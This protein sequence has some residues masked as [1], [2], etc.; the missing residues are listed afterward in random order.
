MSFKALVA[1]L[2][3]VPHALAQTSSATATAT[4]G[5]SSPSATS[6]TPLNVA[7][8]AAGKKYFGSATDNHEL[9]DSTYVEILSD[10]NMFGQITPGNSLKWDA[11][12]PS[13]GNFTFTQ[14]DQIV[15][16]AKANGQLLRGHNCVWH[17]QLPSWVTSGNF[18]ADTLSSI[19]TTHCGTV[20]G[21]YQGQICF[22]DVVNEPLNDDGTLR[23]DVFYDTLGEEYISI[24]LRAAKAADPDAKLY[25]NDYGIEGTGPKSTGMV[26]LVKSLK[27]ASVPIDGIGMQAHLIVGQVP[28]TLGDNIKQFTALGVE[29]AITELD[30][31]MTL[32]ATDADLAQQKEDY[33]RVISTCNAISGCIGV[34][35]WDYTDKYSWVPATFSG[36]GAAL[37]WDENFNKKPAYDGIVAG[38]AS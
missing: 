31:R 28:S 12:E 13:R 24:A 29:V 3:V 9:T 25:I 1:I 21:R 16:L 37:P 15:N 18:S 7:A 10:S 34:T 14:G 4:S 20:V 30:L 27:A 17:N 22:W 6:T 36:Q 19:I 2:C 38:F 26:N 35:I 33:Q 5:A 8:K 23:S 32:P 11:T